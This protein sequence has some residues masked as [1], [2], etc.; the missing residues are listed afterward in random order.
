MTTE[1]IA[2]ARQITPTDYRSSAEHQGE[3]ASLDGNPMS[4]FVSSGK[5]LAAKPG[6]A[7]DSWFVTSH[8][9]TP[10]GQV[11]LLVHLMRVATRP[12]VPDIVQAMASVLDSST[13]RYLSEEQDFPVDL[14]SLS[15]DVCAVVTPIAS[16]RGDPQALNIRGAWSRAGIACDITIRQSGPILANAATGLWPMLG[17]LTYQ[18]AFPT[19]TTTGTVTIDGRIVEANGNS[20]L[21]RQ[22]VSS[23]PFGD[24]R[25]KWV[26]FGICL[27]DGSRLSCWDLMEGDRRHRFATVLS[28]TGVHE[29]VAL[30]PT[31]E[32]SSRPW[33]SPKTGRVYPTT[34]IARMP[35]IDT[36][37][38]MQPQVLEQEFIS[39]NEILHKYEASA[40]VTGTLHGR[41]VTGWATIEL[42]GNWV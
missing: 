28:P 14:C 3:V 20:W 31:V 19:M 34:W 17:G 29:L 11:D 24:S 7:T 37:L 42:V 38:I 39:P 35:G 15:T 25:W 9:D 27:D 30:E 41:S 2:A 36:E 32:T 1:Q 5:D 4:V 16:L 12:G 10:R 8:L 18:Y 21:D 33:K 13:G 26:W 40:P 22:W 6:W 23:R